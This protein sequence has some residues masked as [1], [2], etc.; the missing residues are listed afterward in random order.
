MKVFKIR[1]AK[2]VADVIE[3]FAREGGIS[4]E[5]YCT[6]A[7]IAQTSMLADSYRAAMEKIVDKE[8]LADAIAEESGPAN[9]SHQ[10]DM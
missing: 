6:Q 9:D 10:A 3:A 5:A 8:A 4:L 1:L 2:P 7:V